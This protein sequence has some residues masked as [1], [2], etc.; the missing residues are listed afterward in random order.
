MK[1]NYNELIKQTASK[2]NLS[3]DKVK[4]IVNGYF[5]NLGNIL[6]SLPDAEVKIPKFCVFRLSEKR[7][8]KSFD[9]DNMSGLRIIKKLNK[10][11]PKEEWC[12][13]EDNPTISEYIKHVESKVGS[14][15]TYKFDKPNK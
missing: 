1:E 4:R 2:L 5:D 15:Y 8:K 9:K 12:R 10:H 11:K 6:N 13:F 7:L 14:I 3:Q